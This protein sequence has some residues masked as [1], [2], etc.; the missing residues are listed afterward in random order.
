MLGGRVEGGSWER[1]VKSAEIVEAG[2]V[3]LWRRCEMEFRRFKG[4]GGVGVVWV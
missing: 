3:G 2:V 1:A 4:R